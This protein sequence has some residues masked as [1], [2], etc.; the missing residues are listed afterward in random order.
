MIV[1]AL[2]T[3]RAGQHEDDRS[4]ALA[5]HRCV[6]GAA[7]RGTGRTSGQLSEKLW[8]CLSARRHADRNLSPRRWVSTADL[9]ARYPELRRRHWQ[10]KWSSYLQPRPWPGSSTLLWRCTSVTIRNGKVAA[11]IA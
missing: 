9:I 1:F 6:L 7:R 4:S 10:R 5:H 3:D 2:E 8:E 11:S